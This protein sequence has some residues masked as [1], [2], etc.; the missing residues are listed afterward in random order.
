MTEEL[1]T[2]QNVI[3][4][5]DEGKFEYLL[6][7]SMAIGFYSIPRMT[8]DSDIIIQL[9]GKDISK[10]VNLLKDDF[11]IDEQMIEDSLAG[12]QM[13]NIFHKNT[14][15]KID[16]ILKKNEEYEDVKFERK[17]KLKINGIEIYVISLEDLI[18]SKLNWARESHSEMQLNDIPKL[19][20]NEHDGKYITDWVL[21][22]DLKEIYNKI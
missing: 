1:E 8:R 16:F 6:H 5:L 15:F 20:K 13:F 18:I 10:F 4:K 21:K 14:L 9:Y 17:K 3:N 19:I 22:L 11:F 12:G 7:G 2:L